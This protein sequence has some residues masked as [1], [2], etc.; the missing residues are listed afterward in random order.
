M[1]NHCWN[2]RIK[3]INPAVRKK[4]KTCAW[5][6]LK[7]QIDYIFN[8]N[9]RPNQ[10]S[11]KWMKT[12]SLLQMIRQTRSS[13]ACDMWTTID[14]GAWAHVQQLSSDK[15]RHIADPLTNWSKNN[16]F[17]VVLQACWWFPFFVSGNTMIM[18][19]FAF[20]RLSFEFWLIVL[21]RLLKL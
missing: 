7:N 17:L 1:Q 3:S 19:Y 6:L 4:E 8:P 14:G 11:T 20:G 15:W 5:K 10:A 9:F 18:D 2:W 12:I 13:D 21:L 16:L